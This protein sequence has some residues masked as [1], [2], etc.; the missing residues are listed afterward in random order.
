MHWEGRA[1][2]RAGGVMVGETAYGSWHGCRDMLGDDSFFTFGSNVEGG[3]KMFLYSPKRRRFDIVKKIKI[4][5][6]EPSDSSV[7][8]SVQPVRFQ[9][10]LFLGQLIR[11][12]RNRDWSVVRTIGP[13]RFFKPWL[14]SLNHLF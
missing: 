4:K 13:V 3:V 6:I 10:N 11:L 2:G 8:P 7:G 9:F 14:Q 1:S 12:D 5:L